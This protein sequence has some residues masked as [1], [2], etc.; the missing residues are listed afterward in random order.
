MVVSATV[1][2]AFVGWRHKKSNLK[3]S[4]YKI[5]KFDPNIYFLLII[6]PQKYSILL[7]L[8]CQ[9]VARHLPVGDIAFNHR[10]N[11]QPKRSPM[12][13]LST[14]VASLPMM[15][16]TRTHTIAHRHGHRVQCVRKFRTWP[17]SLSYVDG[18]TSSNIWWKIHW[19]GPFHIAF[20]INKKQ[21]N[22]DS[23]SNNTKVLCLGLCVELPFLVYT[24]L[25]SFQFLVRFFLSLW[26]FPWCW[27]V[28]EKTRRRLTE[29][30]RTS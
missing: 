14:S 29:V 22:G 4:T 1:L 16:R 12:M 17:F 20:R 11:S 21:C 24:F 10:M 2:P 8:N 13:E 18:K 19:I 26:F 27:K 5:I 25:F 6:F 23:Q 30:C 9:R 7:C 28:E 15:T 3:R